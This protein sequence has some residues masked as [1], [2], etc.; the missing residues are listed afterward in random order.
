M[1]SNWVGSAIARAKS[2]TNMTA[3]LSTVI[4]SRSW[5]SGPDSSR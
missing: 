2:V 3:P 1:N 5:L 4:N